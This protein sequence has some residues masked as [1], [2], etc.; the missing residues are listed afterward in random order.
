MVD[1]LVLYLRYIG[2][3]MRGQMQYRASFI[4]ES[5]GQF[6]FSGVVFLGI[7]VLFSRFDNLAG[8]SL[9][10]V[11]FL[12]GLVNVAF[13]LADAACVGFDHFGPMVRSGDFDRLLLRPRSTA[14]QL[15]GQELE[16]RRVGRLLQGVVILVWASVALDVDWTIVKAGLTIVT[17]LC[18]ACLFFGLIVLQ[19]TLAFWTTETL[20]IINTVSYGGVETAQYPL[21]IYRP[22]FRH[23][24]TFVVPWATVSYFPT[25]AILDKPDP[26]G[27][28]LWF[29]FVAPL[30]GVLFLFVCLRIWEFGVR[31][32]LSTGS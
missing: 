4:M 8:W 9:P 14:L 12:Y 19:A 26:L 5:L 13:A 30:I 7:V 27:S 24:F 18:G 28:P 6:A 31:H 10:E 16:L 25:L 21:S 32:Y 29:Q 20:E 1:N 11:A 2:I 22:W 17:F 15:A 23:L 3:S